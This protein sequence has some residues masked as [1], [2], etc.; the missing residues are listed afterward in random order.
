MEKSLYFDLIQ[1]NFPKLILAIV[2]KLNYKNQT[3]A[4]LY[5]QAV[6]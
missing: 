6:A 3:A 5:V 2:E 4:V 1:K